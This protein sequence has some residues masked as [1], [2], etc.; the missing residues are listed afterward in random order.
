MRTLYS[1]VQWLQ[2]PSKK[3]GFVMKKG[4]S[5][6]IIYKEKQQKPNVALCEAAYGK[7]PTPLPL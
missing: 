7:A 1:C 4:S 3:M 6:S 5:K 2:I